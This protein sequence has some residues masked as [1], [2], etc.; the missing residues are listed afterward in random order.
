MAWRVNRYMFSMY[1]R[2]EHIDRKMVI[3]IQ[4]AQR[5]RQVCAQ[6]KITAFGIFKNDV[7]LIVNICA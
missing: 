4:S 1:V 6:N 2:G 5:G 7:K 3:K